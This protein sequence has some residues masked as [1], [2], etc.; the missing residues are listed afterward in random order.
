M[1]PHSRLLNSYFGAD[2]DYD[3]EQEVGQVC[4]ACL[5]IKREVLDRAGLFDERFFLYFDEADLCLRAARAGYRSLYFPQV[6]IVHLEGASS[7]SANRN[8]VYNYYKMQLYFFRKH[9]GAAQAVLLYL[10]NFVGFALRFLTIPLYLIKD[11][12]S[13]KVK[14]HFWA[15][16]YHLNPAHL[17]EAVKI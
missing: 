2:F 15:F 10:L 9:Y 7:V 6:S 12:N 14:R 8:R 5:M 11:G 4:G 1:F 16:I 17:K 13:K 3:S